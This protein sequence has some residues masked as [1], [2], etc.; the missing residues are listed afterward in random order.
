MKT[1]SKILLAALCATASL[2]PAA[3]QE[4]SPVVTY[5]VSYLGTPYVAHTLEGEPT[6]DLIINCDEVDCLTFVEYVLAYVLSPTEDNQVAE[7]DFADCL[8]KIRYRDG[9][10]DGYTSRL[11]YATDWIANGIRHGFLEDVT[12]RNTPYVQTVTLS[13]MTDHP[14]EYRQLAASAEEVAKMK[15]IEKSL[16][17]Q[18]VH[19]LPQENLP[20]EGLYWIK[21]GDLIA[22]TTNIP[23]LDIAHWGIA[24]YADGKLSLLHAS[25][26]RKKVVVSQVS[27][28]QMLK[29]NEKWTGI[30]VLRVKK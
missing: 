30:R 2:T 27:L 18:E 28:A 23:G 20:N 26:T 24:F 11:H 15:A 6:E 16:S 19:Y 17:G 8:Q 1:I 7:G 3:A 13:Y 25:S 9:K 21:N 4:S 29:N 5:G 14:G 22:I 12:A 10:I